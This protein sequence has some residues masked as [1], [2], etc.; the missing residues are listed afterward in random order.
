MRMGA[1]GTSSFANDDA[2]DWLAELEMSTEW[3]DVR[4]ALEA[5]HRG[6]Y[7]DAPTGAVALAAAEVVA[8]ARGRVGADMPEEVTDWLADAATMDPALVA[9]AVRAVEAVAASGHTSELRTL[10]DD[11]DA[12]DRDAWHAGVVDLRARLS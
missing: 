1:W 12:D 6:D 2:L 9:L 10:W 8:A 4:S 11:A 5:V 7:V 3:T